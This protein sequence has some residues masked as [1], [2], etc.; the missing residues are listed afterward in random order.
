[1]VKGLVLGAAALLAP[2]A[3]SARWHEASSAHFVVYAN[4]NPEKLRAFATRLERF[5][6]AMRVRRQVPDAEIGRANRLNVYVVSTVDAVQRLAGR[7]VSNVAGFYLA[8]ASGPVAFVPRKAGSGGKGDLDA[9]TIFFHEYAHHFMLGN[10]SG[11][12]PA[13]FTEGDAEFHSTAKIEDDGSVGI[14]LPAN[15]RAFG[16]FNVGRLPLAKMLSGDTARLS[17]EQTESLY[18]RGWLLTHFLSFEASRRGQFMTYLR[19]LDEGKPGIEAATAAFGDLARLDKELDAYIKRPK[20]SYIKIP[21]SALPIGP[22][23]VRPLTAGEA[24]FMPVRMRSVRSVDDKA[25]K[26]LVAG[27]R[28]AAAPYPSHPVVQSWLAEVEHDANNY[29]EAE[30]AA[31]R[32]LAIDPRNSDGLIYKGRVRMARALEA[33]ATDQAVWRDV[34]RWFVEASRADTE[35]A[36]P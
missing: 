12:F 10:F 1:M 29:A 2:S 24:A 36:E 5:D 27:A 4:D 16:A 15:H 20:I 7:H 21:A 28:K 34:R 30:A 11:T 6:K 32:V 31:D 23:A 19:L 8:R 13:W 3:A 33:K 26:A 22:V 9:D 14:G 25:A 18:G 35:D 17:P